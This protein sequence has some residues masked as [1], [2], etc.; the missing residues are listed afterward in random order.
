V[1]AANDAATPVA[2]VHRR[3][4]PSLRAGE[5][6][7]TTRLPRCCGQRGNAYRFGFL[8][9]SVAAVNGTVAPS[10]SIR[11]TRRGFP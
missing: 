11:R 5:Q 1:I 4:A 3:S 2:R 7:A 8:S 6:D 9:L 10:L